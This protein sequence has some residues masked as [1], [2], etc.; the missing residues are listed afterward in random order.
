MYVIVRYPIHQLDANPLKVGSLWRRQSG[1]AEHCCYTISN[2]TN[3][4]LCTRWTRWLDKLARPNVGNIG[5]TAKRPCLASRTLPRA[6]LREYLPQA[7]KGLPKLSLGGSSSDSKNGLAYRLLNLKKSVRL[8]H[9]AWRAA[10]ATPQI[11]CSDWCQ[12]VACIVIGSIEAHSGSPTGPW[13]WKRV[14]SDSWTSYET[15]MIRNCSSSKTKSN[16]R[17]NKTGGRESSAHRW[18]WGIPHYRNERTA[19]T[20]R[21]SWGWSPAHV[22]ASAA[23]A[24]NR[25]CMHEFVGVHSTWYRFFINS[26]ARFCEDSVTFEKGEIEQ[27]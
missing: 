7:G 4:V 14:L 18:N 25:D 12:C 2:R 3:N 13:L 23:G 1:A 5:A 21:G 9:C 19:H 24:V 11:S 22:R 8:E 27:F 20:S 16:S 15:K 26:R 10:Y 6:W 17:T